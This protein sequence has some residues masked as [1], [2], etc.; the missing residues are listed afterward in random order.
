MFFDRRRVREGGA[1]ETP[2]FR[3]V[4]RDKPG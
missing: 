1:A 3:N 4:L 2:R